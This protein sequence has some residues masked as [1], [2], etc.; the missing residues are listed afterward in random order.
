MRPFQF[1]EP[2]DTG[3]AILLKIIKLP[4]IV[5]KLYAWYWQYIRKDPILAGLIRDLGPK[6]AVEQFVLV[7]RREAYR[8]RFFQTWKESG[9]DF[10][11][12]VPHSMPALPHK[13]SG[14]SIGSVMYS[15]LFNIVS[16]VIDSIFP[17]FIFL[18]SSD[19]K[20]A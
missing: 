8:A 20:I 19:F 15:F 4:K 6:T 12:T 18:V 10:L 9:I 7:A 1:L 16:L 13:G 17:K 11:L 5:R 3:V 14:N 2:N